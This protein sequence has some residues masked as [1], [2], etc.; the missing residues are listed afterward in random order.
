MSARLGVGRAAR[1]TQAPSDLGQALYLGVMGGGWGG[2][3]CVALGQQQHDPSY[4][5]EH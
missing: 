2:P 3:V 5:T 1:A 4:M